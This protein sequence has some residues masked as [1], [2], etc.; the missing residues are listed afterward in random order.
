MNEVSGADFLGR[1][2]GQRG[3]A[4]FFVV[5]DFCGGE[6]GLRGESE[7]DERSEREGGEVGGEREMREDVENDGGVE[8]GERMERVNGREKRRSDVM[9]K[10]METESVIMREWMREEREEKR[11]NDRKEFM[12]E[13]FVMNGMVRERGSAMK[14]TETGGVSG[15]IATG[16][17]VEI[18]TGTLCGTGFGIVNGMF[19]EHVFH[20]ECE[21]NY[22]NKMDV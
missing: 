6:V 13:E 11:M 2:E 9:K 21:E 1:R 8:R 3:C 14:M 5:W 17:V 18:E 4:D 7:R 10:E 19:D 12:R 22:A 16:G 20:D 15:E